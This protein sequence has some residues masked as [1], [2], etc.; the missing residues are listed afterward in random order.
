MTIVAEMTFLLFRL[1]SR[2]NPDLLEISTLV[3]KLGLVSRHVSIM[4][5]IWSNLTPHL[6]DAVASNIFRDDDAR[7][8]DG[9]DSIANGRLHAIRKEQQ[10]KLSGYSAGISRGTYSNAGRGRGRGG[11]QQADSAMHSFDAYDPM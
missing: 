2:K 10:S 1:R 3:P 4:Y 7:A 5:Y 8:L 11:F 9:L 6:T